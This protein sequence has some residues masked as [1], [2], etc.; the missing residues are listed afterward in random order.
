MSVP[1]AALA[2]YAGILVDNYVVLFSSIA[3]AGGAFAATYGVGTTML[4]DSSNPARWYGIKIAA[5]ALTGAV[6]LFVLPA[7]VIERWG[8]NG[9][10]VGVVIA[11]AIMTPLLFWTPARGNKTVQTNKEFAART[12]VKQTPLIWAALLALLVFFSGASAVWAFLERI[13]ANGGHDAVAVGILLSV[14]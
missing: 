10:V 1:A 13:G 2:M 12:V 7:M 4:S 8:F 11:M 6:L 5:E 9:M 3:I 14:T